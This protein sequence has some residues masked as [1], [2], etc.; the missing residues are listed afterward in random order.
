MLIC[1][2]EKMLTVLIFS[3]AYGEESYIGTRVRRKER[4]HQELL[5]GSKKI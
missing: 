1:F 2:A 4:S 5:R 3:F